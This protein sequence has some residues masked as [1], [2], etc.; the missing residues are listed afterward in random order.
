MKLFRKVIFWCHLI[1]GV[2]AGVVILIMSVT[3]VVLTYERQIQRWADVRGYNVARPAA[4]AARLPV[5]ALLS[6]AQEAQGAAPSGV[7]LYGDAASPASVAFPGGRILYVNPY[8]GEALGN[9]SPR[10]RAFFRS[11]TDWHRWLGR[12]GPSRPLGKGIADAA[13]LGFFF[14]VLSGIYLWWPRNWSRDAVRSVTTFRRGLAGKARHFNW[15]NVIGV[16]SWLPLVIIVFSGVM[17]SYGWANR[18]VYGAFGEKPPAVAP[19]GAPGSAAGSAP[20]ATSSAP[21]A[22]RARGD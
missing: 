10:V 18:L 9:G 12:S 22:E 20:G 21:S 16:W 6:K 15:H 1:A 2:A 8:T 13:N 17:I 11:V 19:A 7:T 3:G 14:I 4:D 5:E